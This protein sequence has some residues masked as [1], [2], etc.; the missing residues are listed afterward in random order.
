MNTTAQL[1]EP[2][3]QQVITDLFR[4]FR[5]DEAGGRHAIRG[6]NFQ[7]WHAVLEALRAHDRGTDYAVILEWQQ[8]VAVLDSSR[9]PT[10]VKF[11]Q[12]K[13]NESTGYW[14][15]R[16]L[17]APQTP[18]A[19]ETSID[20]TEV[21]GAL[22]TVKRSTKGPRKSK[23][24][25]LAKL[26]AHRRRFKECPTARLEFVSDGK[27]VVPDGLGSDQ[28]V[29][30]QAMEALHPEILLDLQNKLRVQLEIPS[31][32]AIDLS[33]FGLA[34][35]D[36]PLSDPHKYVA[37]ELAEMQLNGS[38]RLSGSATILAVLVI[39]SYVNLR[40]GKARFAKNF[41]EL[42]GRAVTRSD[43]ERYLAAANDNTVSTEELIERVIQRMNA[44]TAPFNVVTNMQ[45]EVTRACIEVTNRACP[46]P[47]VAAHLKALYEKRNQYEAIPRVTDQFIAWHNDLQQLSV[48]HVSLFKREYLYCL[49]AMITQNANPTN[50][51][52]SVSIDPKSEDRQ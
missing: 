8:D 35:S 42:L 33:D 46:V 18:V 22:P 28:T 16:Q 48:P 45:R 20:P 40:A 47:I 25:I 15:L 14:K 36:C 17:I 50:R 37:G 4:D 2:P 44:E 12:L 30:S 21:I 49:M 24:S 23:P 31:D 9:S 7:V 41:Q 43:I 34:V 10:Q 11:V 32:E 29:D 27:F 3:L 52:P 38:L 51:L 6:F 26:Y 39:A 5:G 13:K 19:E 1:P